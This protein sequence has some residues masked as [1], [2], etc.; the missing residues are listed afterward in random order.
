VVGDIRNNRDVV[1]A[2]VTQSGL[3]LRY[4]DV[5][6]RSDKDVALAAVRQ[7]G[8]ALQYASDD[9]RNDKSVVLEATR[10]TGRSL[11]FASAELKADIEVVLSA[12]T[13]DL[14][15]FPFASECLRSDRLFF[16]QAVS[17][18]G[19]ILQFA[20]AALRADREVVL[21]ATR[22]NNGALC[23]ASDVL[24]DDIELR[25]EC[26]KTSD[27]TIRKSFFFSELNKLIRKDYP[28]CGDYIHFAVSRSRILIESFH[29]LNSRLPS[30][31]KYLPFSV[32]FEGE[33][34]IDAGG[35]TREWYQLI[36]NDIGNP[37]Y[38]L[39]SVESCIYMILVLRTRTI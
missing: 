25:I 22:Q 9:L 33:A 15:A 8:L 30:A 5:E 36:S 31:D 17:R 3:A 16:L 13:Q 11:E 37:N 21:V 14:N 32:S 27:F 29:Q 39:F 20:S 4:T 23:Y 19:L 35:L 18:C 38:V 34:G 6:F 10:V 7:S 1:L 26:V 24:R 12:L 28:V 2:A